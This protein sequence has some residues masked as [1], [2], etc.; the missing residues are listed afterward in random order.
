MVI[1]LFLIVPSQVY[2]K[3]DPRTVPNNKYG[4]HVADTNDIAD[5]AALVNSNGGDWGYV[6]MVIQDNDRNFGKW[7]GIFNQM[8]RLHLIPIIRLA[9]HLEGN[10][11][12]KPSLDDA[13]RWAGFLNSLNWPTIN[14]YIIVFNEPNHAKE[15]GNTIDPEGYAE[16]FVAYA[17]ALKSVSEDFFILPAGFDASA[18]NTSDTLDAGQFIRRVIEAKSEIHNL[19]D[20]WTSHSYPNPAFSGSPYASGKGTIRSYLWE[21]EYLKILGLTKNLPVFITET[22]WVNTIP[23][24]TVSKNLLIASSTVW[25]DPVITAITPF[26]FSYQGK[27]FDNFSWKKLGSSEFYPHYFDYQ[28]IP[29]AIGAP[30][31]HHAFSIIHSLLPNTLV[32]SSNY[33]LE[34]TLKNTGQAIVGEKERYTLSLTAPLGFETIFDSITTFE[35]GETVTIGAKLKTSNLVGRH[36]MKLTL[37]RGDEQFLIEDKSITI[38]PPPALSIN[39]KLGWRGTSSVRDVTVLVYETDTLLHK[40]TGLT[41]VDGHVEVDGLTGIIPGNRYR[42]VTVVPYYLPRQAILPL[43]SEVTTISFKRFFPLDFNRDGTL[44]VSDLVTLAKSKPHDVLPRFF[45][46]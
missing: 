26:V 32:A 9:T 35:P 17:Q 45:A 5:T 13:D 16:I 43:A 6:T 24:G 30:K 42:V 1:S 41:V 12:T 22:G 31:Q 29:K 2:G 46:P 4:I 27:P 21:L 36:Q 14:R 19:I 44:N 20:G 15:W 33:N 38:V 37:H 7:Q 18:T 11:W 25:Q 8:R 28:N 23:T 39:L 40:F 34:M 10:A 3:Y